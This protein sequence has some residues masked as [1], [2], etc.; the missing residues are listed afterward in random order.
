[1]VQMKTNDANDV[2]YVTFYQA[3]ESVIDRLVT[4]FTI[5]L[6]IYLEQIQKKQWWLYVAVKVPLAR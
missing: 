2:L 6:T 4:A 5:L 1:M 3:G